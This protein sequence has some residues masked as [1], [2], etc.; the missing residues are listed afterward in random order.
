MGK[1][2]EFISRQRE[3]YVE[4]IKRYM[5]TVGA[6]IIL[7]LLACLESLDV[8]DADSLEDAYVFLSFFICCAFFIETVMKSVSRG[9]EAVSKNKLITAH[10]IAAAAS[11]VVTVV[12]HVV[13]DSESSFTEYYATVVILF[14]ILIL[15]GFALR[16]LIKDSG[17]PFEKY[18]VNLISSFFSLL[19]IVLVLNIG[20]MV[21]LELIDLLLVSIKT[22]RI[23]SVVEY[24]L[25]GTVYLPFVLICLADDSREEERAEESKLSRGLVMYALT[26]L[27]LAA[28]VIIYLYIF[29]ILLTR[30]FPTNRIFS[31]C[32]GLFSV[33]VCIWTAAYSY[34]RREHD[35]G[36]L[37]AGTAN[38]GAGA[39]EHT[40]S[41]ETGAGA[42]AY[43]G[44]TN[45]G[46]GAQE[47][48]VI[49][50]TGT[51]AQ[52]HAG[53]N[54]TGWGGLGPINPDLSLPE[55]AEPYVVKLPQNGTAL[56]NTQETKHKRS[57]YDK[58]I[59]Y[60]KYI[61]S[62]LVLLEL[63]CIGVRIYDYGLTDERLTAI[64]F[65]I[66][67]VIY[68]AWEPLYNLVLKLRGKGERI[69]LHER[70]EDYLYAVLIMFFFAV[71]CPITNIPRLEYLSQR[72]RLKKEQ[73]VSSYR[74]LKYNMYGERYLDEEGM[75]DPDYE[76]TLEQDYGY[77]NYDYDYE[78]RIYLSEGSSHYTGAIPVEGAES[79]YMIESYESPGG[80]DSDQLKEYRLDY[81][82]GSVI[83]DL[84]TLLDD[85][86]QDKKYQNGKH[87]KLAEL[88]RTVTAADGTR[89]V[90]T[91]ISCS[92]TESGYDSINIKGYVL[93]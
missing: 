67:Q 71:I 23:L 66:A 6:T 83:I 88:P 38:T 53:V 30:E 14:I 40:G 31:I 84:S 33:G 85:M 90:I 73:N 52:E 39:Q 55:S 57:L 76:F 25:A 63:Y 69:R 26:P 74:V 43:V 41:V 49:T 24:L 72:A 4:V 9:R 92:Y 7:S 36:G 50:D 65:M 68:I 51:V 44:S 32:A 1:I 80:K 10:L 5:C 21:I 64:W 27:F 61:Y 82:D 77:I 45:T 16:R 81:E 12:L 11:V 17:L 13:M 75:L 48:T 19:T 2:K 35:T 60:M 54:I 37:T 56:R 79:V 20:F 47:H 29:K 22:W 70:Y 18:A 42:Q 15:G 87:A 93:K 34:I 59:I 28:M 91:Y 78:Q 58:L 62:P 86:K 89:V 46:A 8:V 3:S